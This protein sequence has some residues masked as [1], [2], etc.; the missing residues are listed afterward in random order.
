MAEKDSRAECHSGSVRPPALLEATLDR[1]ESLGLDVGALPPW[2]DVDTA[3]DLSFLYQHLRLRWRAGE[4][5]CPRTL[6]ILEGLVQHRS[7]PGPAGS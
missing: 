2:Y 6:Y 5:P 4:R 3:Q 7:D 1:I